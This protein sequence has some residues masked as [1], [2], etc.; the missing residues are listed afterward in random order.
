VSTPSEHLTA[1]LEAAAT[2]DL[3]AAEELLPLVYDELRRLARA[4]LR[5]GEVSLDA[6]ALVH[7]AYLKLCGDPEPSFRGRGHFFAAAALAMRHVLVDRARRSGRLKRGGGQR[8]LEL[9]TDPAVTGGAALDLVDLDAALRRLE[10]ERPRCARVV[11]MRFFAGLG[12]QEIAAVLGVGDATVE[13]D[14]RFAKAWLHRALD[15]D[16]DG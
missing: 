9:L 8:P 14:W 15:G 1:R 13:R 5:R 10:A 2:G 4:R 11:T 3:A 7:E 6:T 16:A 12:N